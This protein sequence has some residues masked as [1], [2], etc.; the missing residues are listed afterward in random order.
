MVTT[1]IFRNNAELILTIRISEI[2]VPKATMLC[3]LNLFSSRKE[4]LKK[5]IFTSSSA[6][7]ILTSSGVS[8][9]PGETSLSRSKVSGELNCVSVIKKLKS[10]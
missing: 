9:L 8:L 1:A 7:I 5:I 10:H 6:I 2:S 3:H 4:T